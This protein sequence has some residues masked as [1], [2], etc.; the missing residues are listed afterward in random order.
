MRRLGEPMLRDDYRAVPKAEREE[1]IALET[2]FVDNTL[3]EIAGAKANNDKLRYENHALVCREVWDQARTPDRWNRAVTVELPVTDHI[4]VHPAELEVRLAE[5]LVYGEWALTRDDWSE[6]NDV[7]IHLAPPLAAIDPAWGRKALDLLVDAEQW[8][9]PE[10]S[11]DNEW[12]R[13]LVTDSRW[14]ILVQLGDK[15][16]GVQVL[17]DFL[18]R[19]PT[20]RE[21]KP[22]AREV[23]RLL[24]VNA[25]AAATGK[26]I[27]ACQNVD[28]DKIAD[29]VDR[30][31]DVDGARGALQ[32]RTSVRAHCP[33]LAS[34]VDE[35]LTFVAALHGDCAALN[36]ASTPTG[37]AICE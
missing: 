3:G 25:E 36:A 5:F 35:A 33:R 23:E 32:L 14:R 10:D 4:R 27:A 8:I 18:Q 19:N 22:M 13:L 20:S 17:Q 29:E 15:Q 1:V 30:V 21:Y 37:L 9:N 6:P 11:G 34:A 2:A 24:G 28:R 16:G 31:W 26:A 12:R 7:Q